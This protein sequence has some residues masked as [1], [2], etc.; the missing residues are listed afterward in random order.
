MRKKRLIV[1]WLIPAKPERELFRELIRI[2]AKSFGAARFE[3]HLTLG[4]AKGPQARKLSQSRRKVLPGVRAGPIRLRIRGVGFSSKF[5]KTVFVRF[6][7]SPGLRRLALD[8]VGDAKS[9]RDPHLSLLYT[10][11]PSWMKEELAPAIKLP[12]KHV[13]FDT[14]QA[15]RCPSPTETRAEVE[16]WRGIA[17]KRLSG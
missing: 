3:P 11:L 17:S 10:K 4:V 16:S 15:V 5:T 13:V 12:L 9:L 7:P 1:Y 6:H 8:V 2:L 14:L